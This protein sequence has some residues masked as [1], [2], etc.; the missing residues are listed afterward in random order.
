MK[1]ALFIG[2]FSYFVFKYV[3]EVPNRIFSIRWIG[4]IPTAILLSVVIVVF[5]KIYRSI[6]PVKSWKTQD[7]LSILLFSI[8]IYYAYINWTQY[9]FIIT[10]YFVISLFSF[11]TLR[12]VKNQLMKIS[13]QPRFDRI[14]SFRNHFSVSIFIAFLLIPT[15]I[16]FSAK[17]IIHT[18]FHETTPFPEKMD[19][20]TM[21][22]D[23][24]V[25]KYHDIYLY[26]EWS[27]ERKISLLQDIEFIEAN[28]SYRR[29]AMVVLEEDSIVSGIA[30]YNPMDNTIEIDPFR[31]D[32]YSLIKWISIILHEGHHAYQ[33][34]LL[35]SIDWGN[36]LTQ[37]SEEL[38]HLHELHMSLINYQ[39]GDNADFEV[40][41]NQIVEINARQFS[42]LIT[43]IY[44]NLLLTP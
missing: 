35:S 33:V 12:I 9:Y 42:E 3:F 20:E 38:A 4:L 28:V 26:E 44:M 17:P 18:P 14:A 10:L 1:R 21:I 13:M 40:Y 43:P 7:V 15:I 34:Q 2:S 32:N 11:L 24:L 31:F 22:M 29:A 25:L 30:I 27:N 37:N 19:R 5:E 6:I 41:Y 39:S 23:Y 36:Q 8:V 16:L